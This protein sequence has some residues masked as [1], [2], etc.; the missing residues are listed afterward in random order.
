MKGDLGGLP[1]HPF[2]PKAPETSR[3]KP[4]MVG[5]NEDEY[6]FFAWE[7]KDTEPFSIDFDGIKQR[8]SSQFGKDTERLIE[9]YRQSRPDASAPDIF[10][11]INS[12]N[13]MGLGSVEIAERKTEQQAAP[14]YLYHLAINQT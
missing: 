4:L 2:D 10:V 11:A 1:H 13:T 3:N 12:I 7:R 6:T 9:T 14:V 8:L 5:W